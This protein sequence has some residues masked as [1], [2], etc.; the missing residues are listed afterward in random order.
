M[1]FIEWHDDYDL[2]ISE[3]DSQHHR[4]A[5]VVNRFDEAVRHG[6]GSRIM[7]EI[8][9]ELIGYT[10]EHFAFEEKYMEEVGYS[11]LK[12][13]KAQH[14]QLLQKVERLQYEFGQGRRRITSDVRDLLRYWLMNHILKNDVEFAA[15][16]K[17][18]A[19]ATET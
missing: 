19:G 7:N 3:L 15:E 14:R 13:H 10:Q 4:L 5:E 17:Q 18:G 8:L 6:H 9:N 16:L 2:G 1:A 12:R 11:G